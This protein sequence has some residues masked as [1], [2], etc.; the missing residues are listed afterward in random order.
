MPGP[1]ETTFVERADMENTRVGS[2]EKDDPA[3]VARAGFEAMMAGKERA[4]ASWLSARVQARASRFVPD[5]AKA[6]RLRVMTRP[7]SGS[8]D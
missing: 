1:T 6:A 8:T 5:S 2:S 7:G 4:V 3:E